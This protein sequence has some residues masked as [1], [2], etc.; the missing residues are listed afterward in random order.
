MALKE[1]QIH[2]TLRSEQKSPSLEC[3][4]MI[5][6]Q[7]CVTL[8]PSVQCLWYVVVLDHVQFL[9]SC[10]TEHTTSIPVSVP[11][12]QKQ[13]APSSTCRQT[14]WL[15][16]DVPYSHWQGPAWSQHLLSPWRHDLGLKPLSLC[17]EAFPTSFACW[18]P[19]RGLWEP[20]RSLFSVA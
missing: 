8:W 11:W 4:S 16:T 6:S 18:D 15:G 2:S 14:H 5:R 20:Q 19:G 17:W 10:F 3:S 1:Y 12:C 7:R 9:S 13:P